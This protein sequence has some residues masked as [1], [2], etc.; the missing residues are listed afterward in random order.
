ML[1]PPTLD[2]GPTGPFA[3]G[4]VLLVDDHEPSLH[5]LHDVVEMAGHPCVSATSA[6]DALVYCDTHPPQVVVTDLS[7]PDLD[8][9]GLAR[10]LTSRYPLVPIILIT[11]EDLDSQA[12]AGLRR[13]FTAVLFKPVDL[14]PFLDLLDRL[15]AT[16]RLP[17]D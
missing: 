8:G 15:M 3:G 14:E 2:P 9:Q 17:G 6:T 7:M 1:C 4:F 11:G 13:K 16:A 10:W 12:L 5:R